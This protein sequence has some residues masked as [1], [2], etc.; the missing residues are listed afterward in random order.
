[1]EAREEEREAR[2]DNEQQL[3]NYFPK[4]EEAYIHFDSV[5]NQIGDTVP[6]VQDAREAV[7]SR[8]AET[9]EMLEEELVQLDPEGTGDTLG[10]VNFQNFGQALNRLS[11]TSRSQ[12]L[13]EVVT[14]AAA[15]H[16]FIELS[17]IELKKM[18]T[19]EICRELYDCDCE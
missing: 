10:E 9:A 11:Q 14:S 5:A 1:M 2:L 18:G 3:F 16:D 13:T 4:L 8:P 19:M 7:N 6:S 15:A 17:T 12:E